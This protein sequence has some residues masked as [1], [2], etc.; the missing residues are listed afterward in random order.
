MFL[1]H[2]PWTYRNL[3]PLAYSRESGDDRT[4]DRSLL[5]RP[6]RE[7]PHPLQMMP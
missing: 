4:I 1:R 3:D 2:P 7:S 6:H 5:F